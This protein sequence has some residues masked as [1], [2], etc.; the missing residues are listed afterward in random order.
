MKK[1]LLLGFALLAI[2]SSFAGCNKAI[3]HSRDK[4][5][6]PV[7]RL[8]NNPPKDAFK[9]AREVL[10]KMGYKLQYEDKDKGL[11]QTGWL[12]TK[13]NS[14]YVDLFDHADYGTVGAY[15]R[16]E[17]QIHEEKGKSLVE[18]SAP[19]RGIIT[20][21]VKSSFREEKKVLSKLADQLRKED[22]EITNV[23][24]QE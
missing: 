14:H 20:G 11:I 13:P 8:Y 18:V 9:A 16:L 5:M 19:I 10:F 3:V 22:F 17:V 21:R 4:Q 1:R 23:G 7:S 24:V 6:E 2:L 12:S 15:Y